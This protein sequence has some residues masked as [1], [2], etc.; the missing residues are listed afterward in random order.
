MKL[1]SILILTGIMLSLG[2]LLANA[3]E[4]VDQ[5]GET[6]APGIEFREY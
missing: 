4:T 5:W 6:V 1:L 3:Q 2:T